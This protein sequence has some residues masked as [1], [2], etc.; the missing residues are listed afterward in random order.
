MILG[1][2]A[3][4]SVIASHLVK[5]P[6]VAEVRLADIN[7]EKVDKLANR[8]NSD[9]V[10]VHKVDATNVEEIVKA[11]EGVD[12]FVN[13][14]SYV[15]KLIENSME[16]ALRIKA[17]Y[18]DLAG[19]RQIQFSE[20]WR[21]AN[22][23]ALI[24]GGEDPGISNVLAKEGAERLDRVDEIRIKDWGS[25]DSK[26]IIFGWNPPALWADLASSP[27]VFEN[28]EHKRLPPFSGE[29]IYDFP[30][31][32]GPKTVTHHAHEEVSTLSRFIE[33]VKYVEFKL[34][35][36]ELPMV[37]FII[38]LGL[39]GRDPIEVK[40]VKVSPREVLF[41]LTPPT[42]TMD[43]VEEKIRAGILV[44]EQ[45]C[46]LVD[47]KG[48]KEGKEARHVLYTIMSLKEA[49]QLMP[50]ATGVA[51][52]TGT[53]G[54]VFA[55]MLLDGEITTNGAIPPECLSKRERAAFLEHL[56]EKGI[57]IREKAERIIN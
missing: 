51:Y 50:G 21:E 52:L 56:A 31:P 35:T 39:M 48:E 54:A 19:A 1:V 38:E 16:A 34:G 14:A 20:K 30:A 4:G 57:I 41:A 29:E 27:D 46:I 22:L 9:K 8:L 10:R 13:A 44:D 24:G 28:G 3:Q 33:G 17:N 32:I 5:Y 18:L 42:L 6:E 15:W 45:E 43:E 53:S 47:V 26:E 55:K 12:L 36:P 2:G 49:N 7:L 25:M 40:G 37:K 23:T 11:A